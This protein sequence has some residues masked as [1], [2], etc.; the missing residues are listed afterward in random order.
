MLRWKEKKD[1]KSI[2]A[3]ITTQQKI[4]L[5]SN[6]YMNAF[7]FTSIV[8]VVFFIL[9]F[10]FLYAHAHHFR[11]I[12]LLFFFC[13][14]SFCFPTSVRAYYSKQHVNDSSFGLR[15]NIEL[16]SVLS[17][18]FVG[19]SSSWFHRTS[20][21][22]LRIVRRFIRTI[23]VAFVG[24]AV[25]IESYLLSPFYRCVCTQ[26]QSTEIIYTKGIPKP[27]KKKNENLIWQ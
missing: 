1:R 24:V 18:L 26:I 14:F 4:L 15:G 8:L 7:V 2:N 23:Y 5:K 3:H 10:S 22:F 19:S 21:R 16:F 17:L 25:L 9:S 20:F 6:E 12:F 13:F 11:D 27:K